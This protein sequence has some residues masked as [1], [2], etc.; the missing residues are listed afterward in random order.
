M[1]GVFICGVLVA[2]GG[3]RTVA[4]DRS[5]PARPEGPLRIAFGDCT[6]TDVLFVSGPWPA[7][8]RD[9]VAPPPTDAQNGTFASL[10][11]TGDISSGFDD[12][13]IYGG[14]LGNET[15]ELN[16]GASGFQPGATGWGTIGTGRY[17][18]IGRGSSSGNGYSRGDMRGRIA[19]VPTVALGQPSVKGDL[20]PAIVRRYIKRNIQKVDYC[21]EK[22]LLAKPGIAGTVQVQFFIT[23]NGTVSRSDATGVDPEVASCVAGVIKDIEFPKPKDGGGVSVNY[24]F[25]FRPGDQ[26]PVTPVAVA[27][28]A[29]E[30]VAPPSPVVVPIAYEPGATSPLRAQRDAIAACVR[31]SSLNAGVF[32][33]GLAS[34]NDQT[35]LELEG[36]DPGFATC[37]RAI[38]LAHVPEQPDHQ[39]CSIA[40]GVQPLTA[41]PAIAITARDV[42]YGPT[43]VDR[44]RDI[45]A[46]ADASH[47]R[48]EALFERLDAS[49][50]RAPIQSGTVAVRGVGMI[51]PIDETPMKVVYRVLRTALLANVDYV[52]ARQVGSTWIP[53]RDVVAP[54]VPVPIGTGRSWSGE[55]KTRDVSTSFR[56][57]LTVWLA[58]GRIS[59]ITVQP[60]QGTEA[61]V[62]LTGR[63]WKKLE[64]A[65]A[66]RKHSVFTD[67]MGVKLV[68]D[69]EV[70]YGDLAHVA[71][72]AGEVGFVEWRVT[73]SP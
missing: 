38:V 31:R 69:D 9:E 73:R 15:G 50:K 1:R 25:T 21:Y 68:A 2:C 56:P 36:G 64:A 43:T 20:D 45:V 52:L 65:L 51:E 27:P 29:P 42:A 39:R 8:F 70:T 49:A 13:N 22:Q 55:A 59:V 40:F 44:V 7:A 48:S 37:L 72:I 33:I 28:P 10:T 18:T 66:E 34:A 57:E 54:V 61:R 12:S 71:A 62:E 3:A 47:E 23:P 16:A 35:T 41:M 58:K 26:A 6:T 4:V 17:G 60:V 5:V 30:P 11:G 53:L 24:P 67:R 63:N 32:I 19:A 14:L 46:D